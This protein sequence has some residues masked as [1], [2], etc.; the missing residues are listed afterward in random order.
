MLETKDH[1]HLKEV[2]AFAQRVGAAARLQRWLDYLDTYAE[3]DDRGRTRCLLHKDFAPNS[4]YFLMEVRKPDGTYERWFNG[5][6][7][8][9]GPGE[10][11]VGEP[12]FSVSLTRTV[13]GEAPAHD[14]EVHT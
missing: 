14:W 6:L 13:G 4:F 9:Y 11:G 10:T 12:Q 7:I 8:Y 3:N 2:R 1:E 5:G